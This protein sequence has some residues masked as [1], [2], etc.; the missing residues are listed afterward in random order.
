MKKLILKPYRWAIIFSALLTGASAL[1]L[2]E[3]FVLPQAMSPAGVDVGDS[4]ER[5][6]TSIAHSPMMATVTDTAYQDENVSVSIETLRRDGSTVYIADIRLSDASYLKAALAENTFGKNIKQTTSEIAEAHGAIFAV[7]GDYYGFRNSGYV[8][9]NGVLYRDQARASGED[10]LVV[11]CNGD[12]SIISESQTALSDLDMDNVS[13][14]FS[15]GPALLDNGQI[16]VG[17][18]SEVAQSKSSNPRTAIG[19]IGPLHYVVI[20]SDGRTKES[21][22]LSLYELAALFSEKGCAVAY[23]LDGGGS[24]TMYFNGRI[25]NQP[26]DGRKQGERDVSDIVYIGY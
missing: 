6:D 8:L 4:P 13:Q 25:L 1:I 12:F 10:A 22:G 24:S 16:L 14:I 3:A 7:N 5:E 20:V 23:N 19:Q 2:L 17:E 9:R 11:D 18:N 21:M 26:T 15:F